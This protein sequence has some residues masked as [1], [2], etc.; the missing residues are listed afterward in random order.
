MVEDSVNLSFQTD[1]HNILNTVNQQYSRQ[2]EH[3]LEQK[4][5]ELNH[6]AINLNEE[7]Q[8]QKGKDEV[9]IKEQLIKLREHMKE[10]AIHKL[11]NQMQGLQ[12]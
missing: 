8:R 3:Y 2:L 11:E 4:K 6:I 5:D 9:G 1:I 12:Q 7:R 10:Q